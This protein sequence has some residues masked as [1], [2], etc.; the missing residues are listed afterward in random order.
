[1]PRR[2]YRDAGVSADP[3]ALLTVEQVAQLLGVSRFYVWDHVRRKRPL[4]PA[5]RISKRCTRFR[6]EDIR[7]FTRSLTAKG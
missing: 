1:M 4:I 3:D 5:V 6:R 2:A 7:E